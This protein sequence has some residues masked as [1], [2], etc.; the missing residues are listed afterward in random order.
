MSAP[1][2][3]F[4]M[5]CVHDLSDE[6]CQRVA[7]LSF[8]FNGDCKRITE[9]MNLETKISRSDL[10]HWRI[11]KYIIAEGKQMSVTRENHIQWLEKIRDM[12][13]ED[14]KPQYRVAL[15]AE[16]A[17]GQAAGLYNTAV[18]DTDVTKAIEDQSTDVIR[19]QLESK[20]IDLNAI[21]A[22][23]FTEVREP[24]DDPF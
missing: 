17:R 11:R 13:L 9:E 12:A 10:Q 24:E 22:A 1:A 14:E 23:E 19:R 18:Q 6:Q 2:T 21:P 5:S 8:I 4:T 20:G 7:E 16:I 3:R 15:A